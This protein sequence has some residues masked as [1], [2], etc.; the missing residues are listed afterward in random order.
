MEPASRHPNIPRTILLDLPWKS[1]S[2]AIL[3]DEMP[4]LL[5]ARSAQLSAAPCSVQHVPFI[6]L[7]PVADP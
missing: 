3:K 4:V 5:E 6:S 1:C 2:T 7:P